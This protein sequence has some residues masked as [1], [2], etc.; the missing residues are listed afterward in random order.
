MSS[1]S[2]HPYG[3]GKPSRSQ[4]SRCTPLLEMAHLN[5]SFRLALQCFQQCSQFCPNA[6][7]KEVC[8]FT[9]NFL[10]LFL[11]TKTTHPV[12]C[13]SH[14][15]FVTAVQKDPENRDQPVSDGTRQKRVR[16][17]L[18]LTQQEFVQLMK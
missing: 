3:A 17:A 7:F 9:R 15:P 18:V 1:L 10:S 6:G 12:L 8:I 5:C 14:R 4:N 16:V 13:A 11:S 2:L